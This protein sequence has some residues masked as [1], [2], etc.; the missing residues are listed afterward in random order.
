[1]RSP[2]D[3][4][5]VVESGTLRDAML[6]LDIGA[7][8]IA[9]AVGNDGRLTGVVTDGDVRRALLEGASLDDPLGPHLT[10]EFVVASP[11]DGRAEVLDLMRARRISAVPVVNA[12]GRP[13]ALHL[14]DEAIAPI[15]RPNVA[16]VM[17]GGRGLRLQALTEATPKPMLRVAGRPI[18]E[19]I[20]LHLVGHGIRHIYLA[21]GYL[22]QV[23]E[24]HFGDGGR[25][26]AE[27]EYLR[28]E[29]PLGTGGALGLLP[30][31]PRDALLVMNGD[32]VTQADLGALLDAH[33]AGDWVATIGVR[34]YVHA[35]PFGCVDR[36]GPRI[37]RLE[38]KPVFTREVNTGIYALSPALVA[39][40]TPGRPLALPDLVGEA[41]ERNEPVAAFEIEGDWIDVGQR[42]QLERARGG[43][44]A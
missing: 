39:R 13:I 8:R 40:V 7:R 15:N 10:R 25:F 23:I 18:L 2:F 44:E 16:V 34:R 6:A 19:R 5:V 42:E 11:R 38:E 31:P 29:T 24:D 26:G 17:A 3:S 21:T 1:M 33:S 4:C 22:G 14:I 43:S 36:E 20:V 28:E 35:I 12:A 32:L 41:L 27:I 37:L 9:L 30:E